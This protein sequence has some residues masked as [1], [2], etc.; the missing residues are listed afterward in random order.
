MDQTVRAG[1]DLSKCAEG[2]EA[3]D[4]DRCNVADVVLVLEDVPGVHL[5]GLVAERDLAG[6][7]V[8]VLDVNVDDI[9]DLDDLG[10][11]LDALPGQLGVVHHTVYAAE[12]DKR[13]VGRQVLDRAHVV[14]ADFNVCP[15]SIF[16]RLALLA[17]DGADGCE[18][19]VALLVDLDDLDLLGGADEDGKVAAARNARKGCGDED[20]V[21][22]DRDDDAALD[23]LNYLALKRLAA[24][25]CCNDILPVFVRV[26]ALLGQ[27]SDTVD[28]ADFN[29]KAFNAVADFEHLGQIC[30]RLIGDLVVCN[31]AGR[32]CAE[33]ESDLGG[34]DRHDRAGDDISCI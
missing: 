25:A 11:M 9:A 5:I 34:R 18:C 23:S 4:L 26:Y 32:L 14:L 12:I 27:N 13:T 15:E 1:H 6:L 20:A 8:E 3:D 16:L 33:I 19:S 29:H 24:L 30:V 10:R 28:V 7:A 31:Y 21:A 2:R 22:L 17:E